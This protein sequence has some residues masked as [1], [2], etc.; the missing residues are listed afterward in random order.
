MGFQIVPCGLQEAQTSPKRAKATFQ[1]FGALPPDE[2]YSARLLHFEEGKGLLVTRGAIL[3][4]RNG[5]LNWNNVARVRGPEAL[6][7]VIGAWLSSSNKL[8]L[9]SDSRSLDASSISFPVTIIP[10]H[11]G[12]RSNMAINGDSNAGI[13]ITVGGESVPV[14]KERFADLPRYAQGSDADSPYVRVT[15]IISVSSDK[16]RTWHYSTFKSAMGYLDGVIISGTNA[17]AWGPYEILASSDLGFSWH[18]VTTDIPNEEEDAYPVSASI[19]GNNVYV[20]TKSGRLLKGSVVSGSL[21]TA[22]RIP[23][24]LTSLIF[25][26]E[27]IGFG[28]LPSDQP[29]ERRE[30]SQLMRTEDGGITWDPILK[31]RRIVALSTSRDSLCGASYDR[32]FCTDLPQ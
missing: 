15:P 1:W 30:Q 18:K 12:N 16:A 24:P 25:V 21:L 2:F 32:L 14:T 5:G 13:I 11:S 6:D 31:T 20:S 7:G 10:A 3:E 27:R 22:S 19:V 4:S 9:L 8:Y 23:S 29:K 26:D 28:V 17:I